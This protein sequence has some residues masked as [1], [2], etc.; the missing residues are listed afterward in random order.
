MTIED[1]GIG[2]EASKKMK[3]NKAKEHKS[4]AIIITNERIKILNSKHKRKSFSIQ[5]SDVIGKEGNVAG[6]SIK[7]VIPFLEL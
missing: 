6:T 1:N 3:D 4:L 2:I 7:F 5:I